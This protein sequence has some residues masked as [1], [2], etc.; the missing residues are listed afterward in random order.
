MVWLVLLVAAAIATVWLV[1]A[2]S[3]AESARRAAHDWKEHSLSVMLEANEVL[4]SA[5]DTETGQRGYLLT[6][7]KPFLEPYW[8]GKQTVPLHVR[9]LRALV[10]DNV[11]QQ[12]RLDQLSD[13]WAERQR[14]IDESIVMKQQNRFTPAALEAFLSRGKQSM[15]ALHRAV[16]AITDVESHLLG[17]REAAAAAADVRV[18]HFRIY[19]ALIGAALLA[20]CAALLGSYILAR[21]N[22]IEHHINL[23]SAERVNASNALLQT[24][25]D[26]VD[27]AIYV[28]D[29]NGRFI[30]ANRRVDRIL[31]AAHSAV[32]GAMDRDFIP[33]AHADALEI[34]DQEI[35]QTGVPQEVEEFVPESGKMQTFLSAKRPWT[36]GGEIVG[37]IGI[38]RNIT[39]RKTLEVRMRRDNAE[40]ERKVMEQAQVRSKTW[41]L[42][43]D[44]L[45]ALNAEG[46]F[47]TSNPAWLTVLGWT[48]EEVAHTTI[49][50]LLHPDDVIATRAGFELTQAGHAA[51]RFVNRYRHKDGDYRWI[52]WVGIPDGQLVYCSGRDITLEKEGELELAAAQAALRQSQKMES[53]GQLSGG[54]AHDFNNMLA[55]IIGSLDLARRRLASSGDEKV[56]DHLTNA[57]EGAARAADLTARLLAFARNQPLNPRA[58]AIDDIIAPMRGMLDRTL[59]D[60]VTIEFRL[61]A[62][63]A[64]VNID[65]SQL[66]NAIVNLAI[67]ARDAMPD[68]GTLTIA[69]HA[70]G[71]E[72]TI[73][74]AD[75]GC[76]M[77]ADLIA[78]VHE[79][80]FT[81][82][83][84][85][86]GTGLGLSQ[87]YG[88][89][90]QSGGE[91][92][93][94]SA[95]GKGTT[96]QLA[97]PRVDPPVRHA[98]A[99][100][101]SGAVLNA[102]RGETIL[103]VEDEALVRLVAVESLRDMGHTVHE[104]ENG[105][106][107]LE[108]LERTP[109]I[110]LM[111]TDIAMPEMTGR[112]LAKAA[113][114]LHPEL[115]IIYTTGYDSQ[116]N[117]PSTKAGS[118]FVLHKPYLVEEL[119]DVIAT[120]LAGDVIAK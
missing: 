76:G 87:V 93:I 75:S 29:R 90:K 82:K 54:I 27:D 99:G 42:T 69:T 97:L 62:K 77:D 103:V 55:I 94:V 115:K 49:F 72:V 34:V 70:T 15:E 6:G 86:K 101:N 92:G 8:S 57:S 2:V 22:L 89:I 71:D 3:R 11:S 100:G 66:E 43:P 114:A 84:V 53:L 78:R 33:H 38:S 13:L 21:K 105:A 120:A 112:E 91:V 19:F 68:G 109:G 65:K 16:Q 110:R 113:L 85:G 104:A 118:I 79:P 47:E 73:S 17:E 26:N 46:R 14:Q 60:M 67:N 45:G 119:A 80:F 31:G 37:L 36:V 102:P 83:P 44:L 28:K 117:D 20:A 51:L 24:I 12:G 35:M 50:D 48:E 88:F 39:D 64:W 107:A 25:I 56:R 96:I 81:T 111:V 40:L 108:L 41:Q 95:P 5:L 58:L 7:S 32:I 98:V 52:S 59:G 1:L 9:R 74:V 106:A 61:A 10:N 116:Q 63:A 30:F 4:K 23:L 18:L